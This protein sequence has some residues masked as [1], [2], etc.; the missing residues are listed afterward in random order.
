MKM[1][2][3]LWIALVL[4]A[5]SC[6]APDRPEAWSVQRVTPT[7]EVEELSDVCQ[8]VRTLALGSHADE[9]TLDGTLEEL[10][11]LAATTGAT[12]ALPLLSDVAALADDETI[13]PHR[14]AVQ[15]HD[16]MVLASR[17]IDDATARACAIP[18][19]SALYATTGFADC[20]FEMEIPIAAYTLPGT[21]GTC[22][23][24]GR[25]AFLPCW[26][27]DGD[28]LAIDCVSKEIVSAVGERWEPAGEPRVIT[29]DRT[30]PDA[31]PEPEAIEPTGA[32]ECRSLR[33]LFSSSP[34]PNGSTPDFDR[35]V[36]ASRGL[37]TD[38]RS[39]I[40]AFIT[41]TIDPP[42]FSEFETL[43]AA[44]DDATVE[45][46]GLPIVSAWAS[47]T[48]PQTDTLCWLPTDSSYPAYAPA[49]CG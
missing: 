44:L 16:M 10:A 11:R 18:G 40:A 15:Q 49:D 7:D 43:V 32:T 27:D 4:L 1:K 46:C 5:A 3:S 22:S 36:T 33:A 26:S 14:R 28:H 25:P 19:F 38:V 47:I 9:E 31:L 17:S 39:Q 34:L 20:H 24:E 30:D 48:T 2:W 23:T 45:A 13:S 6:A 37:D 41:A 29:I 8:D 21:A 35:L 42:V 12:D